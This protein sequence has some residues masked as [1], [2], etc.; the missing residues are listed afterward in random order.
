M[1]HVDEVRTVGVEDLTEFA[2]RVLVAAGATT[3]AAAVCADVFIH[4][5]LGGTDTHGVVRLGQYAEA[6]IRGRVSGTAR[7]EVVADCGAV[8]AI[9]ANNCLGPVALCR[10]TDIAVAAAATHGVAVVAV[11]GSNHAGGM[12]WY[13]ERAAESGMFALVLTGSTKPMVAPSNG[14]APFLGTNAVAY[15]VPAGS[16]TLGFDASTSMVSR[17][18]LEAYRRAG[19]RLPEGWALGPAGE[20]AVDP[21]EVIDGIDSLA[22]HSILPFGGSD[23]EHK[24]F[25]VGLLVELLC[26]PLAGARWGRRQPGS[27]PDGVGHFVLC[28]DIGALG[29][30]AE[31]V[32]RRVSEFCAELRTTP[33]ADKEI[34]VRAPGDRRRG[35]A[36]RRGREGIPVPVSLLAE[37]DQVAARTGV[38]PL[39]NRALCD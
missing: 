31:D 32:E 5:D 15:G 37:L 19:R 13:T 25:G 17:S 8:L 7:P 18:K 26:G 16:S 30:P 10:A 38:A 34:P 24:G 23:S 21:G 22:G 35:C 39:W 12:S 1:T 36:E 14:A 6:L 29:A 3:D 28:L 20:P 11:R 2:V 33:P 9:E 27:R 4:A